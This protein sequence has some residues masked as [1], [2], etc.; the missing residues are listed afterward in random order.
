M[1]LSTR[2]FAKR[3]VSLDFPPSAKRLL[4]CQHPCSAMV[5]K[6][7][8]FPHPLPQKQPG[9]CT[10]CVVWLTSSRHI[11]S[12]TAGRVCGRSGHGL[13][14]SSHLCTDFTQIQMTLDSTGLHRSVQELLREG[15]RW[16][17]WLSTVRY[18]SGDIISLSCSNID[19][20]ARLCAS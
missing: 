4:R 7:S 17:H 3:A 11:V 9:D 20:A 18:Q 15:C 10:Q 14:P 16:I 5:S 12:S 6:E 2:M 8:E 1:T 13:H 19:H